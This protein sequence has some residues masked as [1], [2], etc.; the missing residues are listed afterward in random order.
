MKLVNAGMTE[1]RVNGSTI[2]L[3]TF[4]C[5]FDNVNIV[6]KL[7]RLS[8]AERRGCLQ[9]DLHSSANADFL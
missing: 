7:S 3:K 8:T 6:L 4:G 5:A 1:R 2:E 9:Q